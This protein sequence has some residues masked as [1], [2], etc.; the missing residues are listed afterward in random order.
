M[1][2]KKKKK[3]NLVVPEPV[4][5]PSMDHVRKDE[6]V[7]GQKPD[8]TKASNNINVGDRVIMTNKYP[9]GNDIIGLIWTVAEGPRYMEGKR[10][11]RLEGFTK[12]YPTDGLKVV[13]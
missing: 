13:G 6:F 3:T 9:V 5:A 1:S 7:D 4:Q 11:V 2:K 12:W 8:F 10:R